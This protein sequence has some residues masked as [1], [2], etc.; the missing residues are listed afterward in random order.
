MPPAPAFPRQQPQTQPGGFLGPLVCVSIA[1]LAFFLLIALARRGRQAALGGAG[2]YQGVGGYTSTGRQDWGAGNLP[3][4]WYVLNSGGSSGG[5]R[6]ADHPTQAASSAGGSDWSA[7]ASAPSGGFDFGSF[8]G[9][10]SGGGGSTG[11]W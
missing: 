2:T 7:G 11:S 10:A 5:V 8:G 6:A 4:W 9:G 1:F 3:F